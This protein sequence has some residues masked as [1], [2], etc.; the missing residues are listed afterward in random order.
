[1]GVSR[2]RLST[3]SR[4]CEYCLLDRYSWLTEYRMREYQKPDRTSAYIRSSVH[5]P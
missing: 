1:M 3:I 5:R 4:N 2:P